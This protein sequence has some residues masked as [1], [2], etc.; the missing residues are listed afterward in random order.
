MS[1]YVPELRGDYIKSVTIGELATHTSGLLLPTDHPPWPNDSFTL[2]QFV[3]MLNAW[4]PQSGERPGKQRINTHAGYVLLQLALERRYRRPISALIEDRI[5]KP[6]GMNQTF[7]PERG[8][9]KRAIMVPELLNRAVQ[10][11]ADTGMAIGPPGDQQ[12]YYDFP[13]NRPDVLLGS[14]SRHLYGCLSRRQ[15]DRS[16]IAASPADDA[17]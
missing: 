9:D 5:L 8:P 13:W 7:F 3:D 6:L 16:A 11:Y 10:G 17:A 12:S 2:Q 4:T 14:R 1:K 15:G